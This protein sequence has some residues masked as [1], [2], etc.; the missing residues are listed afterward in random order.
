MLGKS[1]SS[2]EL[3]NLWKDRPRKYLPLGSKMTD[4]EPYFSNNKYGI[5]DKNNGQ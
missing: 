4:K 2:E 1:P 3:D 5:W